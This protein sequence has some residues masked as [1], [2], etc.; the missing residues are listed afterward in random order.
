[1]TYN[2]IVESLGGNIKVGNVNDSYNE[3]DYSDA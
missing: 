1:M 3:N 2:L